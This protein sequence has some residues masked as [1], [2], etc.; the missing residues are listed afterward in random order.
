MRDLK[1]PVLAALAAIAI[2]ATMDF[3]GYLIFSALPLSGLIL[4]FWLLQRQSRAEIGL[5]LGRWRD[6]GLA[7]AYPLVVLGLAVVVAWLAGAVSTAGTDWT[8]EGVNAFLGSTVGA[9][10]VLLTE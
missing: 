10:M 4:V 1:L 6:Y 8:K 5:T 3:T 2:T 9:L 7:L